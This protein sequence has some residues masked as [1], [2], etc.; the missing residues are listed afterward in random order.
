MSSLGLPLDTQTSLLK[1]PAALMPFTTSKKAW[2]VQ[3]IASSP[4]VVTSVAAAPLPDTLRLEP[5]K[6]H[7]TTIQFTVGPPLRLLISDE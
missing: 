3:E 6:D 4:R 2:N 1:Q 5:S 7:R